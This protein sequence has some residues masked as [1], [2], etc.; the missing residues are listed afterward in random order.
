MK[1]KYC[2][3]MFLACFLITSCSVIQSN[4]NPS[5]PVE[6]FDEMT[7][8]PTLDDMRPDDRGSFVAYINRLPSRERRLYESSEMPRY[9][10]EEAGHRT[11]EGVQEI[12]VCRVGDVIELKGYGTYHENEVFG[13]E[14]VFL[15]AFYRIYKYCVSVTDCRKGLI[16]SSRDDS[17]NVIP[18]TFMTLK[19]TEPGWTVVTYVIRDHANKAEKILY[20]PIA[21]VE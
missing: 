12:I 13:D 1:F 8:E 21:I 4:Q 9:E 20:Y 19:A 16:F 5:I 10:L 3:I 11:E 17:G 2:L 14:E 15:E 7:C 18:G 6:S